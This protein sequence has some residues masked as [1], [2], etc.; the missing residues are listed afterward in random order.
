MNRR[1]F[2]APAGEP[3]AFVRALIASADQV[4]NDWTSWTNYSSSNIF[5]RKTHWG[6]P[7]GTRR[8]RR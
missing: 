5:S 2:F 8:T 7:T 1:G 4:A 6:N 3:L